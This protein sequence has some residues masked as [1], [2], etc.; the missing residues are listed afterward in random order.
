MQRSGS[1]LGKVDP[2]RLYGEGSASQRARERESSHPASSSP[3]A[4]AGARINP[5][6]VPDVLLVSPPRSPPAAAGRDQQDADDAA[7]DDAVAGTAPQTTHSLP[8]LSES[9]HGQDTRLRWRLGELWEARSL[10][11][12]VAINMEEQERR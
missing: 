9:E 12:Y 11:N 8:S 1:R 10:S 6:E 7:D 3:S 2:S 4:A 5:A